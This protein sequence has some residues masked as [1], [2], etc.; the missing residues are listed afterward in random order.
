MIGGYDVAPLVVMTRHW[1]LIGA[2]CASISEVSGTPGK[3]A[4]ADAAAGGEALGMTSASRNSLL[5]PCSSRN[6]SWFTLKV[7]LEKPVR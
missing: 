2:I 7:G 6:V 4:M 3:A 1:A 5:S